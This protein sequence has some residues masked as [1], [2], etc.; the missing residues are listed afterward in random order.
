[1]QQR[2]RHF[3][4]RSSQRDAD[5]F[6][7]VGL[8]VRPQLFGAA[9]LD[10]NDFRYFVEVV[11]RGG[12]TAAS[13]ALQ[14]PKA[15]ISYRIR[16]LERAVDLTLLARNSRTVVMTEAGR[17]FYN[18]ASSVVEQA[19]E[20]EGVMRGRSDKPIGTVRYTVG[21][22]I[23]RF[24]M[25]GMLVG[26]MARYPEVKL[27][28]HVSSDVIDIVADRYDVAIRT[29]ST[30]LPDSQLV[31]RPLVTHA[32]WHLFASAAYFDRFGPFASPRDLDRA[33]TLFVRLD[34]AE[35]MWRLVAEQDRTAV[36]EVPLHPCISGACMATVK[37]AAEAGHG[38]VALPAYI[39]REEVQSG[40]LVRILP[41]WVCGESRVTALMPHRRGMTGA[42]RAFIDHIAAAFPA[43]MSVNAAVV[44]NDRHYASI[45]KTHLGRVSRSVTGLNDA[46][47]RQPDSVRP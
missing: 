20:A 2:R 37:R 9:M 6:G 15:T 3:R 16:Q 35:P 11:E 32:P 18:Y 42:A 36:D 27:I 10:L 28:Q 17:E 39:C 30:A 45:G 25:P 43:A 22:N 12:F 47:T 14:R 4:F 46:P 26:F 5:R 8:A 19:N 34:E 24:A 1:V 41:D 21:I 31:Q 29:H 7:W 38:I 23:A 40:R 33:N 44:E 13:R